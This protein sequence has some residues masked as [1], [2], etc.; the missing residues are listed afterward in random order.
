M[1]VAG[2]LAALRERDGIPGAAGS[3]LGQVV[4]ISMFDGALSWMALAAGQSLCD[5]DSQRRGEFPAWR[6]RGVLPGRIAARMGGSPSGRWSRS[7]GRRSARASD[8]RS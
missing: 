3:G 1:A 8:G 4:D 2:I 6:G 7:S 5:G